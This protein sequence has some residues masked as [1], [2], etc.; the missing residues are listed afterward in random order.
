MKPIQSKLHGKITESVKG[1][2]YWSVRKFGRAALKM[3]LYTSM[4]LIVISAFLRS[5]GS[6]FLPLPAL[7]LTLPFNYQLYRPSQAG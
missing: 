6:T 7:E 1:F 2:G 4:N 3:L 5:T